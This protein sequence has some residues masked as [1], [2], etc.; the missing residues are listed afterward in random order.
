MNVRATK[1]WR[2]LSAGLAMGLALCGGTRAADIHMAPNGDDSH[3]GASPAA[4]VATLERAFAL[5]LSDPRGKSEAMRIVVG[6][7]TY[8]GQSI[9]LD[10]KRLGRD[11]TLIGAASDPKDFPVFA[12]DGEVTTWMTVKSDRG[13]RTGLTIQALE[14]RDYATAI[15]LEGQRDSPARH[16]AGTTIRRNVFSNIGSIALKRDELSTAAIRFVNSRDNVVEQNFFHRIRNKKERECGALHALYLAHFSSSNRISNNTFVDACGSVVKFRDRSNDN[17][18]EGNRFERIQNA[19]VIEEW[20][21]DKGARK[22]CTKKLGECPSTGNLVPS[23]RNQKSDL[24]NSEFLTIN[25]GNSARE[26]CTRDDFA[27]ERVRQK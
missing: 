14:I 13:H 18:V 20:F 19:P 21:C 23:D 12:G 6:Q 7:G 10:G 8:R 22:D 24:Q 17:V 3:N 27:R 15:S 16:N 11:V 25:G 1:R 4:A 2:M 5:A 9:V 26:W